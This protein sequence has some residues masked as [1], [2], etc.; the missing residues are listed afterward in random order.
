MSVIP[1]LQI[2]DLEHT[3]RAQK[4]STLQIEHALTLDLWWIDRTGQYRAR[5]KSSKTGV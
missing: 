4:K 1:Y 3:E 2:A 5:L